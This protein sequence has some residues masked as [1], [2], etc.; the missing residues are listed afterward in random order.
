MSALCSGCAENV[1]FWWSSALVRADP[2]ALLLGVRDQL[3]AELRVRDGD[4]ALRALPRAAADEVHAAV[5]RHDVVGQ[6]AR[7]GDDIAGG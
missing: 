5:L 3:V 7:V 1:K 4:Q 6:T 2:D